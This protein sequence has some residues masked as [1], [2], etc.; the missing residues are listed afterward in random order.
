M[1]SHP[2]QA[3]LSLERM[4]PEEAAA[5]LVETPVSIAA[6]VVVRMA[7]Y[8]GVACL[9]ALPQEFAG[10][11]IGVMPR[12]HSALFLRRMS[13]DD[14]R[15]LLDAAPP[16][17]SRGLSLLL[18]FPE[19]T[20]GALMDPE[21]LSLP[22]DLGVGEAVERIRRSGARI[23]YYL[24]VVNRDRKLAGVIN[25]REL[26][27]APEDAL[28]DSVMHRH[29]ARLSVH[30]DLVAMQAH[31]GWREYHALPVVDDGGVLLGVMRFK[32]LRA[33]GNEDAAAVAQDPMA[34]SLALGELYWSTLGQ[35]L[36]T[37]WPAVK[38][39]GEESEESHGRQS[40][41]SRE[42]AGPAFSD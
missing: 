22:D 5:L 17:V 9:R 36:Q 30:S 31:P 20:A 32:T 24:Y 16:A 12:D 33:A 15:R 3:A 28:L 41:S 26:I 13:P 8:F 21:V 2:D 11:V 40:N 10:E 19:D 1:E 4:P 27:E 7:S 37:L 39:N 23:F 42:G 34:A 6:G 35:L 25:L 38:P 18:R 14:R 29:V